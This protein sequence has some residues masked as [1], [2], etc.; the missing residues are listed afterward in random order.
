MLPDCFRTR[1]QARESP[2]QGTKVPRGRNQEERWGEQ[3]R[4]GE[5]KEQ[6]GLEGQQPL[7]TQC[8][9]P[10]AAGVR[11]CPQQANLTFP[12]AKALAPAKALTA[13]FSWALNEQR[14]QDMRSLPTTE[15]AVPR[16]EGWGPGT[17]GTGWAGRR[18]MGRTEGR[19][20]GQSR[21]S[22]PRGGPWTRLLVRRRPPQS[23]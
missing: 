20:P 19:R 2:V 13:P 1:Q 21:P 3:A 7:P 8:N 10:P 14:G 9:I 22:G 12:A 18:E 23:W 16:A 4:G 11:S 5:A 6:V 17:R 15:T